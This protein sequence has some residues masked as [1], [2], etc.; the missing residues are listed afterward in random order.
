MKLHC[1]MCGEP[2]LTEEVKPDV[3]N[4]LCISCGCNS[5]VF[6]GEQL[7][8]VGYPA[9]DFWKSQPDGH[10]GATEGA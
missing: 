10:L 1:P 7:V 4:L 6:L 3:C 5:V 8:T 9:P 2:S